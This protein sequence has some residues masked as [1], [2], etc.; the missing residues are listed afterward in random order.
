MWMEMPG[1]FGEDIWSK[2]KPRQDI[3]KI[4]GTGNGDELCA[5]LCG[6]RG[7]RIRAA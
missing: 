6:R 1:A 5:P 3:D 4:V 7:G 2:K